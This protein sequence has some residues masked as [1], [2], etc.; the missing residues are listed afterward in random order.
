MTIHFWHCKRQLMSVSFCMF[1]CSK[2]HSITNTPYLNTIFKRPYCR[3]ATPTPD[4]Q[5]GNHIIPV[6]VILLIKSK[7]KEAS[8]NWKPTNSRLPMSKCCEH[9]LSTLQ[10]TTRLSWVCFSGLVKFRFELEYQ[11]LHIL[12]GKLF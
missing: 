2:Q 1:P 5:L 4:I 12:W 9:Q 3:P 10:P 7:Q 6:N 11:V 8:S